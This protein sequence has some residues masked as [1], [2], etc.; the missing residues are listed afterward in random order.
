[1]YKRNNIPAVLFTLSGILVLIATT[2]L[3]GS[4]QPATNPADEAMPKPTFKQ[5]VDLAEQYTKEQ[6]P[7]MKYDFTLPAQVTR[8][9]NHWRVT[10]LL[11]DNPRLRGGTPVIRL[12]RESLEV[13][14]AE[15]H[16]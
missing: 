15:F 3:S 16:Q 1:M 14:G 6:Q 12:D 7:G 13:V 4:S 2:I 5:L 11:P 9:E 10:W 8:F